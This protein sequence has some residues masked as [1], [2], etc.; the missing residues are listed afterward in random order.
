MLD[1]FSPQGGGGRLYN[2]TEERGK[3]EGFEGGN[4]SLIFLP[5]WAAPADMVGFR[6]HSA[7]VVENVRD[8]VGW[9]AVVIVL[10]ASLDAFMAGRVGVCERGILKT[11][12]REAST[13]ESGRIVVLW[14]CQLSEVQSG[15]S[16]GDCSA[17]K[18]GRR[19]S[20]AEFSLSA[21]YALFMP[22]YVFTEYRSTDLRLQ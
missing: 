5:A 2:G 9:M 16:G 7:L 4:G 22:Y 21:V 1:F 11:F 20:R 6:L 10:L 12:A 8:A 17:E 14:W 18:S 3:R 15:Q 19:A 13:G